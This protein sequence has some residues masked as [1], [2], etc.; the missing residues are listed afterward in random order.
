VGDGRR[1]RIEHQILAA[2]TDGDDDDD[3]AVEAAAA[4]GAR[5]VASAADVRTRRRRAVL[6]VRERPA[7]V[8]GQL[9]RALWRVPDARSARPLLFF[10]SAPLLASS[11]SPRRPSSS[12]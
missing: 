5:D 4:G 7:R 8:P 2:A 1:R 10:R 9:S 3:G 6:D 12:I 11:S